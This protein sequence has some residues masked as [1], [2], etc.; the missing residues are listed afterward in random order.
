MLK[1][2][3]SAPEVRAKAVWTIASAFEIIEKLLE[4]PLVPLG[5]F[6]RFFVVAVHDERIYLG[7]GAGGGFLRSLRH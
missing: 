2:Y 5:G 3:K 4:V 6:L 1:L 7:D